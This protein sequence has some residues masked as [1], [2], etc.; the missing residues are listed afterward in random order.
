[1]GLS[2]RGPSGVG[3]AWRIALATGLIVLTGI[4]IGSDVFYGTVERLA[5]EIGQTEESPRLHIWADALQLWRQFPVFGTGLGTFGVV[6]PLVRTLPAPITFTHAES[7]W[8]QLLTDTGILGLL[9]AL[10]AVGTCTFMLLR[11]HRDAKNRWA[12]IFTLASLVALAGAIVQGIANFNFAVMSNFAYLTLAVALSLR[13]AGVENVAD[14]SPAVRQ[15]LSSR[16]SGTVPAMEE[17]SSV[18]AHGDRAGLI[19]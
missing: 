19:T 13:A 9:L 4:W 14:P 6:F 11:R 18:S 5:E 16:K 17:V 12:H 10:L 3:R 7:D 8:I 15:T 1:M 2:A